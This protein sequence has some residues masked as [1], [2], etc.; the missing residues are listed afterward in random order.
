ML[1]ERSIEQEADGEF[2]HK[3]KFMDKLI[4]SCEDAVDAAMVAAYLQGIS[5]ITPVKLLLIRRKECS[6]KNSLYND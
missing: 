3:V 2:I 1:V 6:G 4:V 5:V